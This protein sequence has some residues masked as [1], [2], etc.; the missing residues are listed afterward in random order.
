MWNSRLGIDP[1]FFGSQ[2]P[3]PKTMQ[4][5]SLRELFLESFDFQD[6]TKAIE[7]PFYAIQSLFR[8]SH[9]CWNQV[10]VGI[11]EEDRRIRGISDER[12]SITYDIRR[13]LDVVQRG[14]SLGWRGCD[15]PATRI[16]QERLVEDFR[17]VVEDSNAMWQ[18]REMRA[19]IAQQKAETRRTARLTNA[20]TYM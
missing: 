18:E 4:P 5:Q 7:S 2:I 19:A 17:S 12:T 6:L 1:P 16:V 20:F 11:R 13:L 3:P 8:L 10:N 9:W 15:L 14:G